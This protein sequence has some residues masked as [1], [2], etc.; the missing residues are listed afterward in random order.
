[1]LPQFGR[2]V[3]LERLMMV[4]AICF[5]VYAGMA[6][7]LVIEGRSVSPLASY[8]FMGVSALLAWFFFRLSRQFRNRNPDHQRKRKG[9]R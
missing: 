5:A 3:W 1:M 8:V 2:Y 6:V 9:R 7:R 4:A